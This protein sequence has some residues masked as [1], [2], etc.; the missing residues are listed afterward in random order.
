MLPEGAAVGSAT[1]ASLS[2]QKPLWVLGIVC[3]GGVEAATQV[4]K[5]LEQ[6]RVRVRKA[7]MNKMCKGFEQQREEETTA[8]PT[9]KADAGAAAGAEAASGTPSP[10]IVPF[11]ILNLLGDRQADIEEEES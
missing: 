1:I 4:R 9:S 8:I 3:S 6:G 7:M 5:N 10:P 11:S 2:G